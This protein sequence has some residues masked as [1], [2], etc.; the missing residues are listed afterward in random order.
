MANA[1]AEDETIRPAEM[2]ESR[3][4]LALRR[5]AAQLLAADRE[6]L[7]ITLASIGDGVISTDALGQVTFLNRVAETLTGWSNADAAGRPLSQVFCVVNERTRQTVDNLAARALDSGTIISLAQDALLVSR[8]GTERPID[9]SAA[10]ITGEGGVRIGVVVVFRDLTERRRAHELQARLAAI[11]D[12]SDDAIVSKDLN[13]AILSWNAG[14]ERL[15]G[16]T[17]AEAIGRRIT[18]IIPPDRLEEEEM[19]LQKLRRGE[20]VEPFETVRVARGGR[21]IDISVTMSP[22]RDDAGRVVAASKVARDITA[23]K[24]AERALRESEARLRLDELRLARLLDK[25]R[26]WGKLLREVAGAGLRINSSLSLDEVLKAIAEE[27]MRI[28]GAHGAKTSVN[29]RESRYPTS[30]ARAQFGSKEVLDDQALASVFEGLSSQVR[31]T[32]RSLRLSR[33]ALE[34]HP[35]WRPRDGR[36][37]LAP[38]NGWIAAPFVDRNGEN[39]GL[40]ELFDK[41]AGDF[42]E[43][44]EAVLSQL[45]QI[46]SVAI[47]NARLSDEMRD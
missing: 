4:D 47:E 38:L 23:K 22:V 21:K 30:D 20:R 1:K 8:D 16:Y 10:P 7:R 28:L 6:R 3:S 12:S 18:L 26:A 34:A 37:G 14:A 11:V 13:G 15:F 17:S 24:E 36:V 2:S 44:D 31:A 39:S 35:A 25:E 33:S 40:I 45:A 46:A 27:S 41:D 32:N 19:I 43:D 5:P 29:R 9:D 42:S